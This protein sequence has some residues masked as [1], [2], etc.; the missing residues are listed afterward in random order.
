[1][2]RWSEKPFPG[3][4]SLLV[5]IDVECD[6]GA[7]W[8]PCWPLEYRS[9]TE[10]V[11]QRLRSVFLRHGVKPTYFLSPEVMRDPP[12]RD[13][14]RSISGEVELATHLHPEHSERQERPA[15]VGPGAF[16]CRL[17]PAE[18][19][20]QLESL[21]A[22]FQEAFGVAPRSF[23]AGRFGA[24]KSTLAHLERLGYDNDS[25][26]TPHLRWGD[27]PDEMNFTASPEQPYLADP[28]DLARPGAGPLLEFPVSITGSRV[29]D[30]LR[31]RFLLEHGQNLLKRAIRRGIRPSWLR[32]STDDVAGMV[33]V[34]DTLVDRHSSKG[35]VV[36]V[37]FLHAGEVVPGAT[38]YSLAPGSA[39]RIL[40]R[41][42]DVLSILRARGVR[43]LTMAEAG[44]HLRA[45]MRIP[46][47]A[48]AGLVSM[49]PQAAPNPGAPGRACTT[50]QAFASTTTAPDAT[51]SSQT[52]SVTT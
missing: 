11:G 38:P 49:G 9:V 47:T 23:R 35:P 1:M 48:R 43:S 13:L 25:S 30:L 15:D 16:Q 33:R 52:T 28:G 17:S 29:G 39:D 22:L 26:V 21:T 37:M 12:C 18:E 8:R 36:L 51:A 44:D 32:P 46:F 14:L 2:R 24:G 4:V 7:G 6:K 3:D 19:G 42:D 20:R 40:Q 50:T 34:C 27:D 41:I 45:T 10:G 5:T 31:S